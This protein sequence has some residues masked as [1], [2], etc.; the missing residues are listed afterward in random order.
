M[1]YDLTAVSDTVIAHKKPIT[2]QQGRQL[3]DNPIAIAEGASGAP[4]MQNGG[5]YPYDRT[6]IG[7]A[8][9]G[10]IYD[11][12]VHGAVS[13]IDTPDFED[14]FEYAVVGV[15]LSSDTGVN[16]FIR[17]QLYL[18]TSASWATAWTGS[19]DV[20][21]SSGADFWISINA[22]RAVIRR[23]TISGEVYVGGIGGGIE[24]L[25][26]SGVYNSTDQKVGKARVSLVGGQTDGG[27]VYLYRR[28]MQA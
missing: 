7:G 2:L 6:V 22:P 15:G 27:N 16:R 11:F 9:T 28:G 20:S 21:G 10:L 24:A 18:A 4:I 19:I 26:S 17:V 14:G 23:H 12:A 8:E 5:W 25:A 13:A 1:T 3:R